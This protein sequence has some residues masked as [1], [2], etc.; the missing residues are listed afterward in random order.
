MADTD[1]D[2]DISVSAIRISVS[3]RSVSAY[4]SASIDI[5]YIGIGQTL[6][7]IYGCRSKYRHILAKI[8]VIGQNENIGIGIG[9]NI[10]CENISVSVLV[11]A[12]PISVQP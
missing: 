11:S 6:V 1:T 8:P 9:K 5:G 4:V 2:T 10:G 7:K 3:A 12:G